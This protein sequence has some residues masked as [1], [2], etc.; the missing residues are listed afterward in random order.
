MRELATDNDQKLPETKTVLMAPEGTRVLTME[1]KFQ[2]RPRNVMLDV[3]LPDSLQKIEEYA[4][5][6]WDYMQSITIPTS[7]TEVPPVMFRGCERLRTICN[8]SSQTLHLPDPDEEDGHF[9]ESGGYK[10]HGL[11]GLVYYVDGKK[12]TE[13]PPGKTAVARERSF[14]LTYDLNKGKLVGK[15]VKSYRC[16]QVSLKLPAAKR[17]GYIFLGWTFNGGQAGYRSWY[18]LYNEKGSI[19]GDRTLKARWKKIEVKK[20][21]KRKIQIREY[22]RNFYDYWSVAC[23][24]S[25]KK[26]MRG[27][28]LAC[29][30]R[31]FNKKI[32]K[33]KTEEYNVTYYPNKKLLTVDLKKLKKGKTYYLQFRRIDRSWKG[34]GDYQGGDA[35]LYKKV[36]K[37][38]KV[39]L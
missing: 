34:E 12:V 31:E 21:G 3:K 1:H 17:K 8:L 26:N 30:D 2:E 35:Y 37:T 29:F 24:Y 27:A 11:P 33:T 25:T 36:L 9:Q 13:V 28:K 39:K 23:L 14:A 19:R 32:R 22:N 18:R 16:G 7:V 15:K 38:F 10:Y 4:L 6:Y 20:T 5:D